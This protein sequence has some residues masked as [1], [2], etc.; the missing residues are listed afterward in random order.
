M[1]TSGSGTGAPLFLSRRKF[2]YRHGERCGKTFSVFLRVCPL[3]L[4]HRDCPEHFVAEVGYRP[5]TVHSRQP[6]NNGL[7]V[8]DTGQ[9]VPG[10]YE[11][12]RSL[13]LDLRWAAKVIR[14]IKRQG[15]VL[16]HLSLT[17]VP[18]VCIHE[19]FSET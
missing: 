16:R 7:G 5:D 14:W 17:E 18:E 8:A 3:L 12:Q 1:R 9:H 2:G 13:Q 4:C 10:T 11:A 15:A 6:G 19:A